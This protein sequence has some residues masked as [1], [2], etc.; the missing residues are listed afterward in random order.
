MTNTLTVIEQIAYL[1]FI[2][3]LDS[4]ISQSGT[5]GQFRAPRHYPA[6]G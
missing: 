5:N 2:K 3:I 1:K 6:I 4:R